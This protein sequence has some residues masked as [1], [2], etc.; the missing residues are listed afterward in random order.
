MSL[1]EQLFRKEL[2]E[3]LDSEAT[4]YFMFYTD[5][6]YHRLEA[7]VTIFR[8]DRSIDLEFRYSEN[9]LQLYMSEDHWETVEYYSYTVKYFWM[10]VA[11][12]LFPQ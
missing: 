8:N 2:Q 9:D 11:P 4:D 1:K 5:I 3:F 10:L 6:K 12:V 7:S